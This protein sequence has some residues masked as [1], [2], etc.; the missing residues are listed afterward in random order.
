[1]AR[2]V[3][4]NKLSGETGLS[5][6]TKINE[7]T[8]E[9]YGLALPPNKPTGTPWFVVVLAQSQGWGET[10]GYTGS[11]PA[12][13]GVKQWASDGA[14]NYDWRDFDGD[15]DEIADFPAL[16]SSPYVGHPCGGRGNFVY[17]LS[18]YLK[19]I[20]GDDVFI[21]LEGQ[22]GAPAITFADG[23]SNEAVLTPAVNAALATSELAD[24]GVTAPHVVLVA[25][26]YSNASHDVG[27]SFMT[28][29]VVY[30][31][32]WE[33]N[34]AHYVSEWADENTQF[35]FLDTEW[36]FNHVKA[37]DIG[38]TQGARD[39]W[40]PHLFMG[41]YKL[42]A[43]GNQNIHYVPSQG[44][45]TAYSDDVHYSGDA[46]L[47]IGQHVAEQI[48]GLRAPRAPVPAIPEAAGQN[49]EVIRLHKITDDDTAHTLLSESLHASAAELWTCDVRAHRLDGAGFYRI[50]TRSV[51]Q[52]TG[53]PKSD[54]QF[55]EIRVPDPADVAVIAGE[56]FGNF[57]VRVT[58]VV[59]EDWQF[60]VTVT[61]QPLVL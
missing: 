54:Y 44:Y 43:R 16:A 40:P 30:A 4:N 12:V 3:I 5:A 36:E 11:M 41:V 19:E 23:E 45:E 58:G 27:N 21:L 14:G 24:S 15:S 39:E 60:D 48:L 61:R 51:T 50:T 20:S 7:M 56:L 2:Q 42:I 18:K 47:L 53:T 55:E 52:D 37:Y 46:S 6:R 34:V 10:T 1:M 32:T 57:L 17:S 33:T 49:V 22:S 29:D 59:G 35:Y 38:Q 9:L 13:D 25:Q 8:D 28:S 31:D 26:S